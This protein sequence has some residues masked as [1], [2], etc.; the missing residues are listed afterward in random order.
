[1]DVYECIM[2]QYVSLIDCAFYKRVLQF[3][4]AFF[5][6]LKIFG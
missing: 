4:R 2:K 1:M 6:N 5:Y 3:I